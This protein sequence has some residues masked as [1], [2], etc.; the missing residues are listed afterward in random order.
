MSASAV[1]AELAHDPRGRQ[2]RR[3]PEAR[4]A[5][6]PGSAGRPEK[7]PVA[8][9]RR[10]LDPPLM[11]DVFE[12]RRRRVG[13]GRLALLGA[14]ATHLLLVLL[15]DRRHLTVGAALVEVA[16]ADPAATP[17][18][19][20]VRPPF[21]PGPAEPPLALGAGRVPPL[22]LVEGRALV[23]AHDQS[24]GVL[25][26][27]CHLAASVVSRDPVHVCCPALRPHAPGP[28]GA[29][30]LG[31]QLGYQPRRIET[32]RDCFS[33]TRP[34]TKVPI[35]RE[36]GSLSRRRSRVRVPSLPLSPCKS[37]GYSKRSVA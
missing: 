19:A 28:R 36:K 3:A 12:P 29:R 8:R 22:R 9:Q 6:L 16:G 2:Q 27:Y 23:V 25:R 13:K 37:A 20:A 30:R 34:G 35:C 17:D 33:L 18:P 7:G 4:G 15:D 14:G 31:Y 21:E 26:V 11:L 24:A 1:L 10:G 5:G 32:Y